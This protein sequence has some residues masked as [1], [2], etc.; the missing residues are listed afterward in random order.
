M[1]GVARSWRPRPPAKPGREDGAARSEAWALQTKVRQ[2]AEWLHRNNAPP[3]RTPRPSS[4]GQRERRGIC[5]RR[6][7][8]D[9]ADKCATGGWGKW[10]GGAS[11]LVVHVSKGAGAGQAASPLW[12]HRK[13][14]LRGAC[15]R[16]STPRHRSKHTTANTQRPLEALRPH[17]H[18]TLGARPCNRAGGLSLSS[19]AP[20][21]RPRR[22]T[23]KGPAALCASA[24]RAHRP[25]RR[26]VRMHAPWPLRGDGGARAPQLRESLSR[27]GLT[28][29]A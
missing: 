21:G 15:A 25:P 22:A 20:F 14:E 13:T 23:G 2:A 11:S 28:A 8:Q 5:L 16:R 29:V 3:K 4:G 27:T 24:A 7:A 18:D 9:A 12:P 1:L 19:C 6:Q 26:V 10:S 17:P